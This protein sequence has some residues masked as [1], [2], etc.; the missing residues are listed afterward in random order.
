MS[1][2][3]SAP[4]NLSKRKLFCK[5]ELLNLEPKKLCFFVF[6]GGGAGGGG[7]LE[8]EKSIVIENEQPEICQKAKFHAK[9]ALNLGPKIPYLG[10]FRLE[11]EKNF[12]FI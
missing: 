5:K 3:K 4:L 1:Y 6:F 7:G 9:K 12:C 2:L 10:I 8:L 11:L